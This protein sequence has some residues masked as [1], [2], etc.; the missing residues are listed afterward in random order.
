MQTMVLSLPCFKFSNHH[1]ELNLQPREPHRDLT[2]RR[3]KYGNE[4]LIKS[5]SMHGQ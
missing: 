1:L 3:V 5:A 4:T 2:V